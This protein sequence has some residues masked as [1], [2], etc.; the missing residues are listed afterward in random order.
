MQRVSNDWSVYWDLFRKRLKSRS[1]AGCRMQTEFLQ[2]EKMCPLNAHRGWW[3]MAKLPWTQVTF[4]LYTP[5]R[6]GYQPSCGTC[7]LSPDSPQHTLFSYT[8]SANTPQQ[9]AFL[10]G[11]SLWVGIR[12]C[13]FAHVPKFLNATLKVV[14]GLGK[15]SL[16][17]LTWSASNQTCSSTIWA[18]ITR[19]TT[20][21]FRPV[22]NEYKTVCEGSPVR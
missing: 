10:N 4:N 14:Q 12:K 11:L 22:V 21:H 15:E 13:G 6:L 8:Q 5:V 19:L 9:K 16:I 3:I 1:L 18:N 20:S 17:G 7:G 2:Y